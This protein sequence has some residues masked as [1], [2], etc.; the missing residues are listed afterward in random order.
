ML[1]NIYHL[2][3]NKDKITIGGLHMEMLDKHIGIISGFLSIITSL[4]VI[5]GGI[6]NNILVF[7][8]GIILTLFF[9]FVF[10]KIKSYPKYTEVD[11]IRI[12]EADNIPIFVPKKNQLNPL[13][14][15]HICE[16]NKSDAILEYQYL[17]VC[18]DKNGMDFFSTSLYSHDINN[19]NDMNWFAYDLQNDPNKKQKI[20]PQ[21]QT[22]YG[23]TKRVIFKFLKKVKYNE[24]CSYYTYQEVKNSVKEEGK[25]Y[26]VSTVLYKKRPLHDYKV[27]LKFHNIKP[28]SI[29]VYSVKHRR[30][31]FL[32]NLLDKNMT[33]ENDIYTYIDNIEDETAWSI[34]VY[35]FNR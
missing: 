30:C 9:V 19:L 15:K 23:S 8:L 18:T 28:S 4:M 16:I 22:P 35:I 1:S 33:F 34:R 7:I 14:V 32:Y 12:E 5:F 29:S 6:Q 11:N 2:L 17:G 20:E 24:L 25:D 13:K 21:L 27:V 31:T 26:F 10:I 3:Y